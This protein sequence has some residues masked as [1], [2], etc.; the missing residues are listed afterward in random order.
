MSTRFGFIVRGHGRYEAAKLLKE[1]AVPV[2][3]QDYENEAQ[4]WADLIA[5]NRI[6]ELAE[7]DR[8][9]LGQLLSELK[10]FDIDIELSGFELKGI[11]RLL[12]DLT[13]KN[14]QAEAPT[15][16]KAASLDD[17]KPTDAEYQILKDRKFL[18]EFSGGKDSSAAT[19][20]LKTFFPE[21]PVELMFVDLG[22]DFIGF[23]L[24]LAQFAEHVG[25]KLNV[26]RSEKTVFD[27]FLAKGDWPIFIGPYCHE[28]LHKPIDDYIRSHDAEKVCAVR[29]GRLAEKAKHGKTSDSRFRD[30]ERMRPYLFFEPLYYGAKE[31]SESVLVESGM[32]MWEGYSYGNQRTACRICPGQKPLGYA[33]IRANYPEVWAELLLLEKRFGPGAWQRRE[34]GFATPFNE[35]ADLGQP[36][37]EAGGYRSRKT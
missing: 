36:A 25:Y 15:I 23:H 32:P 21:N 33:A 19:A 27:A 10:G 28:L 26:L 24:F 7:M 5:D 18:V 17:L 34:D 12:A 11:D 3:H 13:R 31:V 37:F 8:D 35:L 9:M 22:A 4:E 29:G 6:A 14:E 30:I 20:W 2:D 16:L 1:A